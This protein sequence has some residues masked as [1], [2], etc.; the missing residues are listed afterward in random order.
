ML[1]KS[2]KGTAALGLLNSALGS[3]VP[4]VASSV[5]G[6]ATKGIAATDALSLLKGGNTGATDFLKNAASEKLTT[7]LLPALTKK[8]TA[9]GGMTAITS[10]LGSQA[11]SLLGDNKPSIASL[12]TT[13]AVDGLFSM[14]GNAEKAE[15]SNPT[16]P[17][18]K[19]IFGN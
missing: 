2:D 12:A 19:E 18:L 6:D 9:N 15:R 3:T 14:M 5:L 11:T 7:A 1:G 16:T 13:G 4:S 17:E 10:A 8:L